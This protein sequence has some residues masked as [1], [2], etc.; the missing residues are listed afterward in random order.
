MDLI[1]IGCF[2]AQLRKERGLTQEQL[3]EKLGVTNK[4]VSRWEK[5]NYLPP[6]EMLQELSTFYE[7]SINELLSGQHLTEME[8]RKHAEENMKSA[9]AESSFTL[10]E[11]IDFFRR[12]WKREHIGVFVFGAAVTVLLYLVGICLH[13]GV[14]ILG[15]LWAVGFLLVQRNRMMKYVEARAFDGSGRQ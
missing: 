13:N 1:R 3:G 2:L 5:G 7:V 10:K 12:K 6:V 8:Y 15:Y 9:L 11:K 4:T 14:Q